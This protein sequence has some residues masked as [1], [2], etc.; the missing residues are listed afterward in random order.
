MWLQLDGS[1][2]FGFGVRRTVGCDELGDGVLERFD[3][4][5]RDGGNRIERELAA[6]G[7]G[8][9]FFELVGVGYVGFGG[10]EDGGLCGESRIE[11]LELVR[12]DLVVVDGIGAVGS[13]GDID[14]VDD[15][16]G[17]LDVFE[18]LD[19]EAVAEMRPFDEAGK[20]G[21]GE[22]FGVGEFSDLDYAEIWFERGEGVVGDFGPG[23]GEARDE[24]GFA[25]VGIANESGIGEEAKLKAVVAFFA[26]AAEFVLARCLMGAGGE[27]LITTA[28]AA[29]L[30]DDDGFVGVG[31]VVDEFSGVVVE[32]EGA[33]GDFESRVL[34]GL[35]G[36]VGAEAVSATL[37]FVLGV[38]T[39]VDER[40]VAE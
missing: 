12:D 30:G 31:E 16:A 37:S 29:A 1:S 34:A 6:L 7:H 38:E 11:V 14:E 25:D 39:E 40:V 9:E 26:G 3:T 10:D 22:R 4:F 36:A 35:A 5:S 18:E 17:A 8:C 27:V 24:R 33:D 20:V 23:S 2:G 28:S 15:D 21:D 19:A 13:V 32:E